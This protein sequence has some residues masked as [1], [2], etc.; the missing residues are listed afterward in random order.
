MKGEVSALRGTCGKDRFINADE[1]I[2]V[3][4]KE[5]EV[6]KWGFRV[7]DDAP[8]LKCAWLRGQGRL[9]EIVKDWATEGTKD[10]KSRHQRGDARSLMWCSE[11]DKA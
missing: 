9:A 3:P 7:T 6:S 4:S 11:R 8:N 10:W 1:P 5:G 2:V